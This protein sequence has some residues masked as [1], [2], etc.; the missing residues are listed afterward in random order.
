MSKSVKS[1]SLRSRTIR[2]VPEENVIDEA[3]TTRIGYGEVTYGNSKS[4]YYFKITNKGNVEITK[5][6]ERTWRGVLEN[7]STS[8]ELII[9]D[10]IPFPS[11]YINLFKKLLSVGNDYFTEFY[12]TGVW[13]Y[14][15]IIE[16]IK[17]IKEGL[18]TQI[19]PRDKSQIKKCKEEIKL[20]N[21]QLNTVEKRND[22]LLEENEYLKGKL[23]MEKE[24]IKLLKQQL[25]RSI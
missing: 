4:T 2:S 1:K 12:V 24:E 23:I 10:D 3:L 6:I 16:L 18:A 25:K 22:K 17:T 13:Y 20:I 8:V 5:K 19:S 15:L 11:L 14:D 7:S 21:Q 9:K